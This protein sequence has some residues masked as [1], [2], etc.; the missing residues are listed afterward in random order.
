M[1]PDKVCL[2]AKIK[3]V[4]LPI[5]S[6]GKGKFILDLNKIILFYITTIIK[7]RLQSYDNIQSLT[8]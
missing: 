1:K 5:K 6:I 2:S 3:Y 7:R 8:K 4:F